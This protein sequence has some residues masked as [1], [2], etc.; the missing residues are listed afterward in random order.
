MDNKEAVFWSVVAGRPDD[1]SPKSVL[2]KWL[3]DR[4]DPRAACLRWVVAEHKKPA[5][6]RI[7]TKTWDWW[8]R[9][10]ADPGHY[11]ISPQ[12]YRL[13]MNLFS[14]LTPFGPG[15]W[16]GLPTF[17]ES[18]MNLASAWRDCVAEKIDPLG[19]DRPRPEPDAG[20]AVDAN[21]DV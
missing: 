12:Q 10:P 6:D 3:D 11:E 17:L 20:L 8:S 7:D 21:P 14:R 2:A 19:D 15:L 4:G 16:K 5:F 1:D 18:L 13:P 9:T